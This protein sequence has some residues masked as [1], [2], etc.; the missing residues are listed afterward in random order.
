MATAFDIIDKLVL[1]A[2]RVTVAN[3][4][5]TDAGL[6]VFENVREFAR[7]DVHPL[8]FIGYGGSD[9]TAE[10]PGQVRQQKAAE[11]QFSMEF[12]VAPEDGLTPARKAYK[13]L[14]KC[15]LDS[16]AVAIFAG[17]PVIS[18]ELAGDTHVPRL[19]GTIYSQVTVHLLIRWI[20]YAG[21]E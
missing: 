12:E 18:V 14:T 2:K 17:V 8:I 3:G 4:F 11:F 15:V 9:K 10:Y 5:N 1:C 21:Q 7:S 20:E 16:G 13:D 19:A 6:N